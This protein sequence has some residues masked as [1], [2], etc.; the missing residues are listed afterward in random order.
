MWLKISRPKSMLGLVLLGFSLVV[1]PPIVAAIRAVIYVNELSTRSE[2]LV[3]KGVR[4]SSEAD[5][6]AEQIVAMERNARQFQVLGDESLLPLYDEKQARFLA[7]LDLI[8]TMNTE[9]AVAQRI[10]RMRSDSRVVALALRR[11]PPQSPELEQ[12]L[13]LFAGLGVLAE[14]ISVLSRRHINEELKSLRAAAQSTRESLVWQVTA[15]CIGTVVLAL[16]FSGLIVRPIRQTARAIRQLGEGGFD[17]R[18]EVDGP[19]ELANLGSELDWLRRRLNGLEQAKNKFL[20]QISHE[21]KT[22]LASIREGTELLIDGTTGSLSPTQIEVANILK[23]NTLQLQNLIEN[24][25]SFNA[26]EAIKEGLHRTRFHISSV[27]SDVRED[28]QLSLIGKHLGW[29]VKGKDHRLYADRSRIRTAL[30]NLV[31]NAVKYSPEG[32]TIRVNVTNSSS[33]VVVE[34]CD[35][36]PGIPTDEQALIFEPFFQGRQQAGGHVRGSGLGLSVAKECVEAH[37]GS[38]ELTQRPA[39]GACFRVTIPNYDH[40]EA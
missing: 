37:G 26:R 31:S 9:R 22:P 18:I 24:L 13:A 2:T 35:D 33:N 19:P 11:H 4:L 38:I 10:D 1:L 3:V 32:G 25:L 30:D 34:V 23:N 36:G 12:S 29:E 16:F 17:R 15:L 21:L 39:A 28:H 27:L 14:E 5:L 8:E 40:E 6:L 7:S 20:R